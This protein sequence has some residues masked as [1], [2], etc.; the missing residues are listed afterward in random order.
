M[1]KKEDLEKSI[2]MAESVSETPIPEMQTYSRS[3]FHNTKHY[4]LNYFL[5]YI[6]GGGNTYMPNIVIGTLGGVYFCLCVIK[7]KK[8]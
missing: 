7:Q 4:D 6:R 8:K 1:G 5:I 3:C 2:C